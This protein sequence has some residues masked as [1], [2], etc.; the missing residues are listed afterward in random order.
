MDPL[1][2]GFALV[3]I[4]VV[5][6]LVVAY[7]KRAEAYEGTWCKNGYI[8]GTKCLC[9]K[10]YRREFGYGCRKGSSPSTRPKKKKKTKSAAYQPRTL[11]KPTRK[12]RPGRK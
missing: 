2:I 3:A 9:P 1:Y 4:L 12:W 10:G 8:D 11:W 7:K 6:A 5:V